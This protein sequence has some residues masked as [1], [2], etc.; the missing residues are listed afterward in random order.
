MGGKTRCKLEV[1]LENNAGCD[2]ILATEATGIY[3]KQSCLVQS[4]FLLR[5]RIDPVYTMALFSL[6]FSHSLIV[7]D[8]SKNI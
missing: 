1:N 4:L 2:A 8:D 5:I 7:H 3:W 6:R